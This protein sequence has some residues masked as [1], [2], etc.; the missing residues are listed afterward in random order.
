MQQNRPMF[1]PISSS[2]S[3]PPAI[4]SDALLDNYFSRFHAKPFC[5]LDESFIRQRLQLNQLPTYLVHAIYAVAARYTP[6][7]SG[8]QSTA[9]LS[10]EYSIRGRMEIDLDEPVENNERFEDALSEGYEILGQSEN[11]VA[12]RQRGRPRKRPAKPPKT[13]PEDGYNTLTSCVGSSEKLAD[14][15]TIHSASEARMDVEVPN[16][17]DPGGLHKR[18]APRKQGADHGVIAATSELQCSDTGSFRCVTRGTSPRNPAT[19]DGRLSSENSSAA[20][21]ILQLREA[22]L[23]PTDITF[24]RSAPQ[25]GNEAKSRNG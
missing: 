18:S 8:H 4:E 16:T 20:N 25:Q 22:T 13:N 5:I 3:L 9:K 12:K 7:P 2:A 24:E 6:H 10:E 11:K 1:T 19:T 17:Q 23:D 14:C 21:T 15:I